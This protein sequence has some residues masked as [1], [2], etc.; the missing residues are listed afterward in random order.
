MD[1]DFLADLVGG[2]IGP[3]GRGTCMGGATVYRV[4]D[5]GLERGARRAGTRRCLLEE[6]HDL[7]FSRTCVGEEA[8]VPAQRA[9]TDGQEGSTQDQEDQGTNVGAPAALRGYGGTM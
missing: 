5:F 7:A 4:A 2:R 1:E 3:P 8:Q 9:N 6:P